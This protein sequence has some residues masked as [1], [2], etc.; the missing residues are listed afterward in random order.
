MTTGDGFLCLNQ[1]ISQFKEKFC[2]DYK[3]R[4]C[5]QS[6]SIGQQVA[7]TVRPSVVTTI[8]STSNRGCGRQA[9]APSTQR[10]VGGSEAVPNS[11]PWLISLQ[12]G[13]HFCGGTLIDT[14]H[15][16]T[17][18]HCLGSTASSQLRVV[19]GLHQRTNKNT[20]R[21]QTISVSRIFIH[22]YYSASSQA[23]DIAV[24]RLAQPVTLNDYVNVICLPGPDPQEY[25]SVTVAGWG[26]LRYTGSSSNS[27]Q[28]VTLKVVN[29]EASAAYSSYFNVQRQIGAGIPREGGKDSCQGDS[30]GPLMFKSNDVWYL[31]GVVSF[32]NGCAR[33]LNPGIYTRTS[34]Y[35]SWIQSK[36]N[37][38]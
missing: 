23:H 10:I 5:C 21:V 18:A 37:A 25:A 24:V 15:V 27:L 20:G 31:S 9:I 32:G 30:G 28:Q 36:V 26:A 3:V 2:A 35:V 6:S 4:F 13:D 14:R 34:T 33:P 22:E 17:A 7:T 11:W 38:K 16:V 8:P 1:Q 12:Y 29:N 19:A